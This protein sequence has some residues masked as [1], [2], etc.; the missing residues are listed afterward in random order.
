[1]PLRVLSGSNAAA[2]GCNGCSSEKHDSDRRDRMERLARELATRVGLADRV[3]TQSAGSGAVER[4]PDEVA[5]AIRLEEER[6]D[7]SVYRI[8]PDLPLPLVRELSHREI[9]GRHLW[10]GS[11]DG[12]VIVLD[13]AE[14]VLFGWLKEAVSPVGVT[15]R[16]AQ[17]D[18][19]GGWPRVTGLIGRLATAGFLRGVEGY[20]ERRRAEPDRFARFHLTKAC[21]LQCIHCYSESSPS[22]DR[23][24]E[25][26]TERWLQVVE[27]YAANGGERVLFTGGEALV[28]Q[29]CLPLMRKASELGLHVTLFS[30][31]LLVPHFADAIRETVDQVQVSLD[32]PDEATNDAVR[33]RGT[34][35]KILRAVDVLLEQGTPVRL[36]MSVMEQNWEAWKEGFLRLAARYADT[37][38]D[39]RLSFGITHYG[40]GADLDDV[41][42]VSDTQPVVNGLLGRVRGE[43]GPRITRATSGCGYCEQFVVGPNGTVYPCHLLDGPVAHVDDRPLPEIIALLKELA[44]LFDVDH[45]EGCSTCDIRYLCGGTCRVM[46]GQRTGS[47]LVTTCTQADKERRYA[48]L[49]EFYTPH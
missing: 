34:Y 39:Y 13:D 32:G 4:A 28:H 3:L 37:P 45:T 9:D 33:G 2:G 30:N 25:L 7:S 1:M 8:R 27:D 12:V 14:H 40:R 36:G 46:N 47:R 48:N 22:V 29:G 44:T 16:L 23:S 24:G 19:A 5:P 15:E 43:A 18:A 49:A 41:L 31:G 21:Q 20:H 42:D 26:S 11:D 38:L 35:G 17:T 10:I 6:P